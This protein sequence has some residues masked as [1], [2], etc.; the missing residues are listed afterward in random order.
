MFV[1]F[2]ELLFFPEFSDIEFS[3]LRIKVPWKY[4]RQGLF[5]PIYNVSIGLNANDDW[6]L[7]QWFMD[8]NRTLPPGEP[9]DLY[10]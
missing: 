8:K 7:L 5:V 9:F 3:S 4:R 6:I 1:P 2:K 10:R